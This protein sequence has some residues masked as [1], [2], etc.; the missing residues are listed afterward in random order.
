MVLQYCMLQWLSA[1]VFWHSFNNLASITQ[2]NPS[3]SLNIMKRDHESERSSVSVLL[4]N[5]QTSDSDAKMG[6]ELTILLEAF[7]K[8]EKA[9]VLWIIFC[10][11]ICIFSTQIAFSISDYHGIVHPCS[12]R[13]VK[14]CCRR[15][16]LFAIE[17]TIK[18]RIPRILPRLN[19][20]KSF[21]LTPWPH[22]AVNL[23]VKLSFSPKYGEFR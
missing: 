15:F 2:W 20:S 18:I 10:G 23:F 14:Q 3:S 17:K 5:I 21:L 16:T 4:W 22:P 6:D 1:S 11:Q 13:K 8:I 19:I 9:G 12:V 7:H